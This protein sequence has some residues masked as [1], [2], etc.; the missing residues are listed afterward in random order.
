MDCRLVKVTEQ[1]LANGTLEWEKICNI[2]G[3]L[4]RITQP[5]S[6]YRSR[7]RRIECEV[8]TNRLDQRSISD[9]AY[10]L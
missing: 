4:K 3:C 6:V 9:Q 7:K 10:L 1:N 8:S 2:S 5:C